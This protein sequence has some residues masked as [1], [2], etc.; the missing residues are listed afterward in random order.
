MRIYR[1]QGNYLANPNPGTVVDDFVTRPERFDFYTG[2]FSSFLIFLIL[3][4]IV[5]QF[6]NQGT[7]TPVCYNVIFDNTGLRPDQHQKLAFKLCHLYYNWQGT[8]RVPAPWWVAFA[9]IAEMISVSTAINSLFLSHSLFTKKLTR[10][11]E[12]AYS[13]FDFLFINYNYYFCLSCLLEFLLE[14]VL[15]LYT[16]F[17]RIGFQNSVLGHNGCLRQNSF[18][19]LS[20]VTHPVI[21]KLRMT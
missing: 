7:V 13:I 11:Y 2:Q 17:G 19:S 15:Y 16:T 9:I 5:P 6:V 12:I 1:R 3:N 18:K 10:V 8:V 14:I 21:N 20:F 4:I